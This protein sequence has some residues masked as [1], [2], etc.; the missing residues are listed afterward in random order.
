MIREYNKVLRAADVKV[1]DAYT[2]E[3]E[4]VSALEL[5]ERAAAVLARRLDELYP[6][7]PFFNIVAGRGDN[8]GDGFAAGRLLMQRGRQARVFDVHASERESPC[9][10]VNRERFLAAGGERVEVW[11][12]GD[13]AVAGEGVWVDALL[14]AGL[15]RPA[16]GLVA[17]VIWWMNEAGGPVVAVDMPSGLFGEDNRGN[18]GE[19]TR[20]DRT[21]TFHFPKLAF[22]LP[23]NYPF[24]GEFEVLDIG[25]HPAI[26]RACP[27]SFFYLTREAVAARLPRPGKFVHKGML[28]HA[29]LVA[30]SWRMMGAAVLAARGAARSGAGLVTVHVPRALKGV[31]HAAVPSALVEA[32][33]HALHFTGVRETARYG[34]IGIGPG[35]GTGVGTAVG[36][37]RLL[38]WWRGSIVLDADAL[39][40]IAATPGGVDRLP[41]GA[42][43]TPHSGEFERLAGKSGND[44]DRLNKLINFATGHGVHVV[45]KG[46]HS[47]VATPGGECYFNMTGNPGMAKGGSGDVLTGMITALLA[48]GMPVLDAVLAGVHVHGL[49]GDIAA[50]KHGRRGMTSEDIAAALGEAWRSCEIYNQK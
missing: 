14:G 42:V 1:L 38:E 31:L 18:D 7:A 8:G 4:P 13:L 45:L 44:F 29:L 49:A 21:L 37:W 25:L 48:S 39:N 33:A 32:D 2:I 46:A 36:L 40:I 15:N 3:H 24:V 47:A 10:A 35:L 11:Q 22:M 23:E 6:L 20:A 17:A 30:G 27:S 16:S 12:A 9:R 41:P 28:G 19:I 5:M 50:A 43:L 34:A 26:T